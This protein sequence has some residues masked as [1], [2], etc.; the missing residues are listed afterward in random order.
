MK[1]LVV[2][3]DLR[4]ADIVRR[5]LAE[6]GYAVDVVHSAPA[7]VEAFE[8]ETYDLVVLDLMLPG[9][10]RGGMDV[11]DRIRDLNKNIPIL[12]L[13]ALDSARNRVEG[14]DA[15]ADDYLV[16]PFHL[17]ELLARV[18]AL[19]RRAP[20]ALSPVLHAQGVTLEPATR[21]ATR[22]GRS[23]AL[24]AKEY[25]VLEYLMSNAGQ[26]IS[27]SELI[28]HAWDSNYEGFSNV[29]QTYIRY[30]RQKLTLPGEVEI[31][32]TRRGSGYLIAA[33]R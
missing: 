31:I 5:T 18:R 15:G 11:C 21:T 33:D 25:A 12:M 14:L 6:A 3:D 32:E 2:E 20:R 17:V 30:L 27:S 9:L 13:T 22:A 4:I 19:L 28:D 23:I 16:K 24:T 26:I 29:V 8:I 10:P 7:G 1:L